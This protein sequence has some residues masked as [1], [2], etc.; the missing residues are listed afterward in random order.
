MAE[1]ATPRRMLD[2][3]ADDAGLRF[4]ELAENLP[5]LVWTCRPDGVSDYLGPQ[6][7]A[8]TGIPQGNLVGMSRWELIHPADRSAAVAAWVASTT[9]EIPYEFQLRLRR[10]DGAWRWFQ[11]RAVPLRDDS[12]RVVKWFGT[13]TDIENQK[14]AEESQRLLTEAA[15]LL[16]AADDPDAMMRQVFERV[17]PHLGADVYLN[18]LFDEAGANPRLV[19]WAGI[20][21]ESARDLEQRGVAEAV[22]GDV[23][24]HRKAVLATSIQES[25]DPRVQLVRSFGIRSYVSRPLLDKD[26]L[27]GTLTFASRHRD[28]FAE[29]DLDFMRTMT[30]FIEVA[31]VRLR[32]V[33]EL[34]EAD[35]RK[36][37]FLATLSHEL[38]NPLAP[39][40]HS[41][42][43]MRLAAHDP[44]TVAEARAVMERQLGQ[45]V[46]LIDDLLDVSRISSGKITLKKSRIELS[47]VLRS[48]IEINR[49]FIDACGHRLELELPDEPIRLEADATRLI[50]VFDNLLHNAA[51]Y[52]DR[53][54][55]IRLSAVR[56][57]RF[58]VVT[59]ADN[60]IGIAP[61]MLPRVFEKFS[62]V[63]GALER[64]QGGLGLGLN[65]V[66]RLVEKHGGA[67]LATSEGPGKG[68]AFVVRLPLADAASAPEAADRTAAAPA[69]EARRRVLV[70]DD[71]RDAALTLSMMLELM[72][73]EVRIAY[74]GHEA[75]QAVEEFHPHLVLLDI[76]MPGLNGYDT[77]R[78]IRA[79]E[80][81]RDIVLVAL[82][83]WGQNED[84]RRSHEAGFDDHIVKPI[85]PAVLEKL[86]ALRPRA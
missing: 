33:E 31:H 56:A 1:S 75:L 17:G 59:V 62:Q 11:A 74:G 43:I 38:R 54:G 10:H 76:G 64:S 71:N 24:A 60:G 63:D 72:G 16:L 6:W 70:V 30:R 35:R 34:K 26:R 79:V 51:K 47:P 57:E 29:E 36:D 14:R 50:Q 53:G 61:A 82:T 67:V 12:G 49:S 9:E 81:G 42:E 32:L 58:A 25:P 2:S 77:A 4:R 19:S 22:C 46:R 68:S 73:S 27:F 86:L 15:A 8:Y 21:E 3:E 5:S 28:A 66:K 84:R 44:L 80:A 23:A 37:D 48:A 85:E 20:R 69:G 18:F 13:H 7:A 52:T 40:R 39:L 83:G 55:T 45:V 78:R 41:L 65:I